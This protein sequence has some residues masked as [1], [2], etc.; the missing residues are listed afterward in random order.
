MPSQDVLNRSLIEE[1]RR[2]RGR[3]PP[4]APGGAP[5]RGNTVGSRV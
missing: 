5:G 3:P 1:F 2:R 4:G